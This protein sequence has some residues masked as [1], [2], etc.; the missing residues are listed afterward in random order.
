LLTTFLARGADAGL[1]TAYWTDTLGEPGIPGRAD[2]IQ[3][4]TLGSS[5]IEI[6][7]DGLGNPQDLALDL[8][9]GKIYWTDDL[10]NRIRRANLDGSLIEDLV[11][12]IEG[13]KGIALDVFSGK[14]YW[15]D[16]F[17]DRIM[18]AN[19]DGSSQEVIFAYASGD[20][21][22][23]GV[24][25]DLVSTKIYWADNS[26]GVSGKILRRDVDGSGAAETV[27]SSTLHGPDWIDIDFQTGDLFWSS[28]VTNTI[29]RN[30]DVVVT[31]I[32]N[33]GGIALD[34]DGRKIYWSS[35]SGNKIERGGM[36]GSLREDV[37]TGLGDPQGIA[38]A[39]FDSPTVI[40][41]PSTLVIWC[42][43]GFTGL[44][45]G[46]WRRRRTPTGKIA[47]HPSYRLP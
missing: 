31:G 24:A 44:G 18:R 40:P 27:I 3:R 20:H 6:V 43:L 23:G 2:N 37:F 46:W 19:L 15:A 7:I 42:L 28:E 35:L 11:T 16:N 4:A 38:L 22:L 13:P 12:G 17:T 32:N 26:T 9:S 39:V 41:E 8:F 34:V 30:N 45:A 33:V 36:D 5:D 21:A 25:L 14:M 29:L 10:D 47:E 1:I